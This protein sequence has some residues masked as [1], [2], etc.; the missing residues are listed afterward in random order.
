MEVLSNVFSVSRLTFSNLLILANLR[1]MG[2][3]FSQK[4]LERMRELKNHL[5]HHWT[6]YK[7]VWWMLRS[8][9]GVLLVMP[10]PAC[11]HASSTWPI[12][13]GDYRV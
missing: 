13:T 2:K 1:N 9:F 7:G 3:L 5:V 4:D 6:V 12:G 10:S 8:L 11:N